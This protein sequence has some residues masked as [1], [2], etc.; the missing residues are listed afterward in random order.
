MTTRIFRLL[1]I[2]AASTWIAHPAA[3][4]QELPLPTIVVTAV[5]EEVQARKAAPNPMIVIGREEIEKTNDLT[6][7]DFLRRQPGLSFTGPA[8]NLKDIRMR[9]LDK[10]YT[11][12]LI[13]GEPWLGSTKERQVQVDQLPMSMVDRVEIIRSPLADMPS[14]GVAGTINIVLRRAE[15]PEFNI[16]G[17][18][19]Y[20]HGQATSQPQ[21]TWQL[22][23][24]TAWDNGWS[25]VMP[26]NV[27]DRYELKTKP[28]SSEVFNTATG[29]RTAFTETLE[30]ERNHV[31]EVTLGPR[32]HFK[33]NAIDTYT[34]FAFLNVNEGEKTKAAPT[35]TAADPAQGR[36]FAISS[37]VQENEDKDRVTQRLGAQWKRQWHDDWQTQV[38]AFWQRATEDKVKPKLTYTKTG[39]L[40]G[41]ETE[42]GEVRAGHKKLHGRVQ[43]TAW[44]DH[45]LASG[46]EWQTESRLDHKTK[47]AGSVTSVSEHYDLDEER[48]TWF[49]RDDWQLARAHLLVPG[50]R[51]EDRKTRSLDG[52]GVTREGRTRAWNPSMAYRWDVRDDVRVRASAAKTLK[53]PKFDQL[54]STSPTL[55]TGINS[56]ANP[57][58]YAG[59]AALAPEKAR[60]LDIGIEHDFWGRT[61][62]IGFNISQRHIDNKID[63]AVRLDETTGRWI[64]MP[65]NIPGTS[66]TRSY[67]LDGRLDLRWLGMKNLTVLGNYSRFTS[68]K[69]GSNEPLA[70]QPHYVANIGMDWRIRS[71]ATTMGWR[72]NYQGRIQKAGSTA[73]QESES[74]LKLLDAYVY[75]DINARWSLRVS[76]SNLLDAK[77]TKLKEGFNTTTGTLTSR[78]VEQESG[79][80]NVLITLEARL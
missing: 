18:V 12:F 75:W 26:I 16:K 55:S 73:A 61:G 74:A 4:A 46:V 15:K 58:V 31:R 59:N 6:V 77:K 48:W 29:V 3:N 25:L 53:P 2:A 41:S 80:R 63:K 42:N 14:D 40:T 32:V 57:D 30:D 13:D 67:E 69:A 39:T 7:G 70:E 34:A 47:T 38:G 24:A 33:P 65:Y 5:K 66:R 71:W 20:A 11:Q 21:Q 64:S 60:G 76:G 72:Y 10:G 50:V 68:R 17:G 23:Y 19:G 27:N 78:A 36:D 22:N 56:A 37:V 1:P 62:L 9:G 51:F 35:W 43:S 28:K 49:V 79:S 54:S 8:G 45:T 44:R 52:D